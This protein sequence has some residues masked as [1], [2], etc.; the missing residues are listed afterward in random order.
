MVYFCVEC[1]PFKTKAKFVKSKD[2]CNIDNNVFGSTA[3]TVL[4]SVVENYNNNIDFKVEFLNACITSMFD[5]CAHLVN[6]KRFLPWITENVEFMLRL[7][8]KVYSKY[9]KLLLLGLGWMF[10]RLI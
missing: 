3:S 6:R 1:V 5:A 7:Q 10:L 9:K 8:D 2:L 4:W